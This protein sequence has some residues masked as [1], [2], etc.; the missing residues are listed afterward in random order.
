MAAAAFV[1]YGN[2]ILTAASLTNLIPS[3]KNNS[4]NMDPGIFEW[5]NSHD[6]LAIV[7][8]AEET[9]FHDLMHHGIKKYTVD[10]A[11]YEKCDKFKVVTII[12][13]NREFI[14]DLEKKF[15]G[16]MEI[17]QAKTILC[18]NQ[19]SGKYIMVWAKEILETHTICREEFNL[20]S[21]VIS[22]KLTVTI[23]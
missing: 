8:N 1:T 17:S 12:C 19:F 16:E 22:V 9:F 18:L 15:V 7:F 5:S 14:K 13:N 10:K 23:E 3:M 20:T 2:S 6:K 4:I 21:E 11:D